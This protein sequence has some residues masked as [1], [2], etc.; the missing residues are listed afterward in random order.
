MEWIFDLWNHQD[1]KEHATD[2]LERLEA[3]SMPC[4][5]EWPAKPVAVFRRWLEVG[6]PA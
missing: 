3:G 4:E 2:I 1:V 6:M 5:T